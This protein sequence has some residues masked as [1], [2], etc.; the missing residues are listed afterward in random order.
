MS[1]RNAITAACLLIVLALVSSCER[2][3]VGTL[4]TPEA[5]FQPTL[6]ARPYNYGTDLDHGDQIAALGRVL[7]YER[8]LSNNNNVS[9]GTCHKQSLSFSDNESFSRGLNNART[10][11]NTMAIQNLS[12]TSFLTVNDIPPTQTDPGYG[13]AGSSTTLGGLFWDGREGVLQAMVL[14][15][16]QNPVE[17]GNMVDIRKLQKQP[18][19]KN[20]FHE[21]F[22]TTS[23][24]EENIARALSVFVS[25]IKV[26]NSKYD[27]YLAAVA[28]K[29]P[30]DGI[31]SQQELD[32]M[33]LFQGTYNCNNCHRVE[34]VVK[35]EPRFAN[36][37]LSFYADQ[38]LSSI[39]GNSG[40]AGKFRVPSL[41]N[42]EFTGPYMHDGSL[43]TLEDVIQHYSDQIADDPNL[44][45]DLR[46]ET[47]HAR[48]M[49]I[50]PGEVQA[51]VAFL[52]ALSDKSV[53]TDPKFSDPFK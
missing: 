53:L 12:P 9:C 16:V 43:Q 49:N 15:P 21:A 25:A 46:D 19:Y 47:G 45:Q 5:A 24:T 52:K 18:Y 22:G 38:G 29:Q 23:I 39:T 8:G 30:A 37:G 20:L 1:T 14:M 10:Q 26:K 31:L 28:N 50:P 33:Q 34:E 48:K 27:Q 51:L 17:M 35:T 6:P 11:R 7:F 42:V 13:S 44:H 2:D 41:R 36:I 32:G 3:E 4:R 40:D